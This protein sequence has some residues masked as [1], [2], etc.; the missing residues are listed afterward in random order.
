[1]SPEDDPT[2]LSLEQ[3]RRA[4]L[5]QVLEACGWNRARAAKILG[6]DRKTVYRMMARFRLDELEPEAG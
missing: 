6:V 3:V 5:L 1:V 2:L 4:H